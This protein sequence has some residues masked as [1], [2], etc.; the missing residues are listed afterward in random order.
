MLRR[1]RFFLPFLAPLLLPLLAGCV[2]TA[3]GLQRQTSPCAVLAADA[4][5]DAPADLYFVSS[6]LPDCS[7]ANIAFGRLRAPAEGFGY[8]AGGAPALLAEGIWLERLRRQ[9]AGT[10]GRVLVYIHGYNTTFNEAT[11][12]ALRM[13]ELSGFGGL[14]I[15]FSW[16]SQGAVSRYTWD[17]ENALWTQ[18]YFDALLTTLL[19]EPHVSE[20]VL[21]AHSMGNRVALRS[22]VEVDRI[23]PGSAAAKIRNVILAAPDIDR[24]IFER[25]Y[26]AM[27]GRGGRR[28]TVY[29]SRVDRP[30]RASWALHGY[31]RAGDS[32]CH[33]VD[34]LR[35]RERRR[36]FAASLPPPVPPPNV[37]IVETSLVRGSL[38]GH[39]DFVE[40]EIGGT[41][42]CRV[43]RGQ[44]RYPERDPAGDPLTNVFFLRR[45]P[46]PPPPCPD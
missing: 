25:D 44:L 17:E 22:L 11:G 3:E 10:D 37:V 13:R 46:A 35:A 19:R 32:G 21:V 6:R 8:L 36:C 26:L 7:G 31:G 12:R 33:F 40:S 30:L 2:R 28:T 27:L 9:L 41:D 38:L 24:T 43:L 45:P 39:S 18:P 14:V 15:A 42:L 34:V 16:P 29:V 23:E 4:Q 1:W 5:P 20:I